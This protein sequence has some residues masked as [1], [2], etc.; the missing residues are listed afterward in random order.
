MIPLRHRRTAWLF[1]L[2]ALTAV[3]LL[4]YVSGKRYV[5]A[6]AEVRHTLAVRSTIE[7]ALSLL[8][9]AETGQ[10]GFLLTDD[11]AFL[12]PYHS[13]RR[14][15]DERLA[16]LIEVTH[17]D[18]QAA[19]SARRIQAL[20]GAKVDELNMTLT[21]AQQG[22]ADAALAIVRKGEGRRV[23]VEIRAEVARML[24]REQI[25]LETREQKA[26]RGQ[27][28]TEIVLIIGLAL[29]MALVSGGLSM[30]RRDMLEARRAS[31]RL[32]DSEQSFRLLADN[33][34]DLVRVLD[35]TGQHVYVSPSCQLLL[36]YTPQELIALPEAA[37]HHPDDLELVNAHGEDLVKSGVAKSGYT[38][39]L[40]RRDGE[41]RWFETHLQPALHQPDGKPRLHL[42]SRD[43]TARVL[44]EN[45]LR[46]Q[47][48]TLQSIVTSLGDGLVVLDR[49][50]RFLIINPAAREYIRQEVGDLCSP[51]AWP[52]E[53]LTFLPDGKTPFPPEQGP[54]TRALR[55][56]PC[57]NVEIAIQDR[58]GKM[59]HL[60]INARPIMDDRRPAGSVAV[61]HDVTAERS[62][63]RALVESEH[64]WR[65]LSESSFEGVAISSGEK[66]LDTNA[67]FAAWLGRE[68][69]ELSG[70]D[71][72]SLFAPEDREYVRAQSSADAA[73]YEARMLRKDGSIFHV[74]VRGRMTEFQG[75]S[76]RIAVVRDI[77]DRKLHEAETVRHAEELRALSLRDE[78]T[79]LYNRRGFLEMARQQLR[80]ARRGRWRA[81]LFFADLN[82]MKTI[83]DGWGH[84][85]GDRAIV[86]TAALMTA[87]FRSSDVVA[88]LGG[89]EFAVFALECD[90]VGVEVAHARIRRAVDELNARQTEPYTMSVSLGA[91]V[92]DPDQPAE[93]E[94]LME[95]ADGKMYQEKRASGLGRSESPPPVSPPGEVQPR[96]RS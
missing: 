31:L 64:R 36:G 40:K 87:S 16:T 62:A 21:L 39:R 33:T 67:N 12:S 95:L 79:H 24:L 42:T 6:A 73:L 9:D 43:V 5:R 71:G 78:M 26:A 8:K 17:D 10:R 29:T 19:Q 89:D 70:A 13:A 75:Q 32:A 45:A 48:G 77:T 54:L 93:L 76:V 20:A 72:L 41:Y 61:Y 47:T 18:E 96:S 15:I 81:A 66:V 82:G 49:E 68:P 94:F 22:R 80:I 4:S 46:R 74:E 14:H 11:P 59:R 23:M 55:G 38:H 58:A 84:D 1:A 35:E 57:D 51:V 60:T 34:S 27:R 56:Q 37:L 63:E 69:H 52:V 90:A 83:N 86:A 50:R 65:V 88:R 85:A 44:A 53:N 7:D 91:A 92:F 3:A 30:V 25:A 28:E 2:L